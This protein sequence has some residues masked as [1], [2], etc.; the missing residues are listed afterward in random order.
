MNIHNYVATTTKLETV[1]YVDHT[2]DENQVI[3]GIKSLQFM[4]LVEEDKESDEGERGRG[5]LGNFGD[6]GKTG[7]RGGFDGRG[8]VEREMHTQEYG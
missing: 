2:Y 1:Q 8:T 3:E 7:G 5:D 4:A 6:R